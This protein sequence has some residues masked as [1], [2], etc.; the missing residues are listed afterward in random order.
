[1]GFRETVKVNVTVTNTA[2]DIA[3]DI[4]EFFLN[5]SPFTGDMAVQVADQPLITSAFK[6]VDHLIQVN[7]TK[8]Y[9]SSDDKVQMLRMK[10]HLIKSMK[11]GN[12][13]ATQQFTV[14]DLVGGTN[15]LYFR[16]PPI[17]SDMRYKELQSVNFKNS[18]ILSATEY[19]NVTF[20]VSAIDTFNAISAKCKTL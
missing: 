9:D 4:Y 13:I 8:W 11:V 7:L 3:Y 15:F 18:D 12:G 2:G 19:V 20:C 14:T 6:A 17:Y 10:I 5:D 1:M 16:I